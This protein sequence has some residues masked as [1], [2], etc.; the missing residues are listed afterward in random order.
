[1]L[2][3][4]AE[5][6]DEYEPSQTVP[7]QRS[8]AETSGGAPHT[9]VESDGDAPGREDDATDAVFTGVDA[10]EGELQRVLKK[11]LLTTATL[12]SSRKLS[13]TLRSWG[14]AMRNRYCTP[15]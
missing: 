13:R 14:K 5:F 1:M 4:L 12:R 9:P 11:A 2:D 8:V 15:R 10:T 3:Q 7:P 6:V